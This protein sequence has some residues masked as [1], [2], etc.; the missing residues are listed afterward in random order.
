ML[1]DPVL[2]P[3]PT[4]K[5]PL[6]KLELNVPNFAPDIAEDEPEKLGIPP[7]GEAIITPYLNNA[8]TVASPERATA[9]IIK[10]LV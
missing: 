5:S 6:E 3:E 1:L 8:K 2:A 9:P 4:A 7:I 10:T